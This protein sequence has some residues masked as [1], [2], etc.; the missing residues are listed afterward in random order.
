MQLEKSGM[1][2]LQSISF[3]Y[4]VKNLGTS[5]NRLQSF[6]LHGCRRK[7]SSFNSLETKDLLINLLVVIQFI[8]FYFGE[9]LNILMHFF[10]SLKMK[11]VPLSFLAFLFKSFVSNIK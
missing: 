3:G 6:L 8:S 10:S 5:F 7:I 2:S 1:T 11:K 9:I 4:F